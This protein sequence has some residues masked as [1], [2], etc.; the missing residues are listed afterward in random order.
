MEQSNWY[1]RPIGAGL[2]VAAAGLLGFRVFG[3]APWILEQRD[4]LAAVISIGIAL[5]IADVWHQASWRSISTLLTAPV[6]GFVWVFGEASVASLACLYST[7]GLALL[8]VHVGA[9]GDI[10]NVPSG[11]MSAI[12]RAVVYACAIGATA[13]VWRW[14]I[15]VSAR[16]QEGL[17]DLQM[18]VAAA[19]SSFLFT[20]G[21]VGR[22]QLFVG[23]LLGLIVG[24][25][26]L[27]MLSRHLSSVM[28]V[29]ATAEWAWLQW[30]VLGLVALF[31]VLFGCMAVGGLAKIIEALKGAARLKEDT[32]GQAR[33]AF[34]SELRRAKICPHRTGI[35]LGRYLNLRQPKL[36]GASVEY[37]GDVHLVTVGR[38]GSGKGTGLIIPN[39]STLRR[40][41]LIVDPKGEAA[42]ITA[43]KRAAF[44]RVVMLNPFNVLANERPWLKSDGFNPLATVRMDRDNFLDD[45]TI[46]AQSLVKQERGGNGRF[47]SGSAHD[48]VTAL[49]MYEL[50]ER[51]NEANLANVRHLLTEEFGADRAGN[52]TGLARTIID[53]TLSDFEP[54]RAKATRF[55]QDTRSNQDVIRTAI[56]ETS[57]I[58]SP[59]VARDLASGSDFRFGDMKNEI[60]TAYL[61][62]PA[63]HL[64]SH[65]NWLRLIIASAL[66]ELLAT[67]PS[68]AL[69]PVLFMLDEFAQ[70]DHLPAISNAMNIARGYGIQLWPFV[71]DLTQLKDIYEDRWE[72]FLSASAAL[73][74]FAPRDIFTSEYLSRLSGNKTIIVES[75]SQRAGDGGIGRSRG[76]QG[77]PLFRPE[78]LRAMPSAQMLCFIEPV[79]VPFMASA[80]GYWTTSFKEGLDPNPYRPA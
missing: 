76:P 47:F 43:R 61:V 40:S 31:A 10:S 71:Q 74:A 41:I 26:L 3:A 24:G 13:L 39:L 16:E 35:Y 21:M 55:K 36:P 79:K 23:G 51:G 7:L 11:E 18:M 65:S 38:T 73:T 72:N 80:P 66:R 25:G 5:E 67:P 15:W 6:R 19:R 48:L 45:C 30:V 68:A 58:D 60:V 42:A 2:F 64:E 9:L 28:F 49:V 29:P 32:H 34:Q 37:P 27:W 8:G 33:M 78:E 17:S 46:I 69:P 14:R 12:P 4:L 70:L 59:P 53:M 20:F 44:G 56:N 54:L 62:L 57:F 63:T 50:L 22:V 75:E 1:W 77:A 52:A